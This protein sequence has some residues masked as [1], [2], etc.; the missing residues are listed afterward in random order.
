[1]ITSVGLAA[2]E[3]LCRC[4]NDLDAL[5]EACAVGSDGWCALTQLVQAVDKIIDAVVDSPAIEEDA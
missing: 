4:G 1:M 5:R 2:F 3:I